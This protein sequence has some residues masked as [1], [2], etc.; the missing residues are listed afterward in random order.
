[1]GKLVRLDGFLGGIT[2]CSINPPCLYCTRALKH[3]PDKFQRDGLLTLEEV[4]L[5]AKAIAATRTTTVELGGGTSSEGARIIKEAVKVVRDEAPQLKIWINVGPSLSQ[6]DVTELKELGVDGITSSFETMNEEVFRR[7]K[8]GDS[9]AKRIEIARIIDGAGVNL[10][11]VL[12]VG[13][14][15]S[16]ENRVE[17]MFFLKQFPNLR[18]NGAGNKISLLTNGF[19]FKRYGDH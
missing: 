19:S 1:M 5:G 3:V 2:P 12:M 11:S 13:L 10:H 8:P 9:L 4:A 15:E 16:Y 17:H 18:I 14:G 7:F 6:G